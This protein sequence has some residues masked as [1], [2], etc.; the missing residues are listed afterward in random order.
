MSVD[1]MLIL[2]GN[3]QLAAFFAAA[4]GNSS[5]NNL[6][7]PLTFVP[8][9]NMTTN[10]GTRRHLLQD[11]LLGDVLDNSCEPLPAPHRIFA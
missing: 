7:I 2:A 3:Q 4:A 11:I 8:P 1:F 6:T 9:S 5:F 10:K